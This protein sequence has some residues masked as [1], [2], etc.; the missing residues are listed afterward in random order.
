MDLRNGEN[1]G[2]PLG[3]VKVVI[4]DGERK[5]ESRTDANGKFRFEGIPAGHYEVTIDPMPDKTRLEFF[6]HPYSRDFQNAPRT[7]VVSGQGGLFL[8]VE[9]KR[10]YGQLLGNIVNLPE[11]RLPIPESAPK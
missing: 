1:E 4:Q 10:A 2:G 9:I 8:R 6:T 3:N 5:F 11:L 7:L